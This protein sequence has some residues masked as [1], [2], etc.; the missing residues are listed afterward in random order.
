MYPK[1][2]VMRCCTPHQRELLAKE[3]QQFLGLPDSHLVPGAGAALT[4]LS[5]LR[6]KSAC[7]VLTASSANSS[8][9]S[10]LTDIENLRL[11]DLERRL[12]LQS[13]GKTES[14]LRRRSSKRA[15]QVANKKM[16]N[17]MNGHGPHALTKKAGSKS[18]NISI[19]HS[20]Q[21]DDLYQRNRDERSAAITL[22]TWW[23][24]WSIHNK[25]EIMARCALDI[26][27]YICM[28]TSESFAG[29][30]VGV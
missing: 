16:K 19:L 13:T 30:L 15:Y 7:T 3:L 29:G 6:S 28:H 18:D 23:R 12:H 1:T 27:I 2:H 14:A 24:H 22:Q 25:F 9:K 5:T 17:I 21:V 10:S 11:K 26:Y 4:A 20:A 8:P